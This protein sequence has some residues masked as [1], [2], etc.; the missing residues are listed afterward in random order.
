[1][2]GQILK[3]LNLNLSVFL[4]FHL[5]LCLFVCRSVCPFVCTGNCIPCTCR[6]CNTSIIVHVPELEYGWWC[7]NQ[8]WTVSSSKVGHTSLTSHAPRNGVVCGQNV[9][10]TDFGRRGKEHILYN[11]P[12]TT[13]KWELRC[14][15]PR[16]FCHLNILL[17]YWDRNVYRL[18]QDQVTLSF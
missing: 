8:T 17:K 11:F 13:G 12:F 9:G 1:M 18:G 3:C 4:V 16:Q 14:F 5:S 15:S 2:L 6:K 7:S 10:L